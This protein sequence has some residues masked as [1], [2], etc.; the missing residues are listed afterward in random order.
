MKDDEFH[1]WPPLMQEAV[2]WVVGELCVQKEVGKQMVVSPTVVPWVSP[3]ID[4]HCPGN[5][6]L[7]A[8]GLRSAAHLLYE[9]RQVLFSLWA[10][11][12][13]TAIEDVD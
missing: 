1:L 6:G 2:G 7:L 8:S 12:F 5:L 3:A 9:L 4:Y 11:V 10:S 13:P